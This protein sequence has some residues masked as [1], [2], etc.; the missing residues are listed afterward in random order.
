MY[1]HTCFEILHSETVWIKMSTRIFFLNGRISNVFNNSRYIFWYPK[2]S[3]SRHIVQTALKFCTSKLCAQTFG[4]EY[5]LSGWISETD[6]KV[7]IWCR[8]LYKIQH[9][10][11]LN[12]HFDQNIFCTAE[13]MMPWIIHLSFFGYPKKKSESRNIVQV[14]FKFLNAETLWTKMLIRIF[15]ERLNLGCL[16]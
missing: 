2:K 9:Q 16:Q 10:K 5:F 14:A 8:L 15:S 13:C 11:F 4:P 12:N 1:L 3:E 6:L 7:K